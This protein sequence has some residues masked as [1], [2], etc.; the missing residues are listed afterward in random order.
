[1]PLISVIIPAYNYAAYLGEAIDSVLTQTYT[2]LEIIV[3]D[4]GST[5]NTRE[6]V[7]AF[8][9]PRLRYIYRE[10][11]GLPAARN[12]GIRSAQGELYAYLDAD[13]TFHPEKLALQAAFLQANPSIGLT[14]NSRVLVNAEAE[15]LSIQRAPPTVTLGDLLLG[16]PIAP[17][18]VLMRREWAWQVGLFDESYRL[19]S[20]DLNFHLRLALAG[21]QMAGLERPLSFRR[22]HRQRQFD[23]IP[24]K[25]ATYLRALD[26]V[27]EADDYPA[28]AQSLRHQAYANHYLTWAYQAAIQHNTPLAQTYLQQATTLHPPLLAQNSRPLNRTLIKNSIRDGADHEPRLKE[29]SRVIR[30]VSGQFPLKSAIERGHLLRGIQNTLWGRLAQ[31]QHHLQ[32]AQSLPWDS[33]LVAQIA[34]IMLN[35][36]LL[37]DSQKTETAWQT[38]L[39][40]LA[41][42]AP[43]AHLRALKSKIHINQG[44]KHYQSHRYPQVLPAMLKAVYHQPRFLFNRGVWSTVLRAQQQRIRS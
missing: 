40:Q 35:L 20:E 34:D 28:G 1:M 33:P 18:D 6:I 9:D 38:L 37:W 43:P 44:F 41:P 42:L 21:C 13:D 2:N 7:A 23:D 15:P 14:Y 32:Q 10:N 25:M 27:F 17:S 31:G 16:Y 30:Q 8:S 11:G 5:D 3:V 39:S 24:G 29:V 19:N 12:T 36:S 26:T 22:V 4:D